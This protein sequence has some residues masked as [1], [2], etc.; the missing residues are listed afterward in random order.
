MGVTICHCNKENQNIPT[1]YTN[2]PLIEE[3]NNNKTKKKY[4]INYYPYNN[5]STQ[6]PENNLSPSE[7]PNKIIIANKDTFNSIKQSNS[8]LNNMDTNKLF[9]PNKEKEE[10]EAIKNFDTKMLQYAEYISEEKYKEIE[11]SLNIKN[12]E[13]NLFSNNNPNKALNECFDR[14]ALLFKK[15][16]SIYKGSWNYCNKKEGYGIYIDSNGN[17][18]IGFW[19][20]DKFN[21]KGCLYATN[22]DF[23]KGD[24]S[25]GKMEGNGLYHSSQE[26]YD[27]IGNFINNKF[28]GK[29][30]LIYEDNTKYEGNFLEGYMEGEGNLLFP[31][32]SFYQGNFEKNKFN[33]KGQF[34]FENG[35]TYNGDWKNNAMDGFG[36]FTWDEE[37]KYKGKYKNNIRE[38]NGVYSFGANLYDGF[39]VNNLPHGKGVLL[40]EGLRIEGQFRYGKIIEITETKGANRDIF[41]KFSLVKSNEFLSQKNSSKNSMPKFDTYK[42]PQKRPISKQYKSSKHNRLRIHSKIREKKKKAESKS[43]E[44]AKINTLKK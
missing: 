38:G 17:K 31:D 12:S 3:T 41:L 15:D 34:F 33:G 26:K 43:K 19:K 25:F 16:K 9:N 6:K 23:Y 28:H 21:G 35:K 39:W 8:C 24:F 11:N 40:N 36:V 30:K 29:G 1:S 5:K 22:G 27:Y 13:E 18:Y 20:N 44:K 10:F 32:G 42:L 14:P 7:S 2:F 37:I 4:R